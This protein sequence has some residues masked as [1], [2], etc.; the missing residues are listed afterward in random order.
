MKNSPWARS[1]TF[2]SVALLGISLPSLTKSAVLAKSDA[3][4]QS[5]SFLPGQSMNFPNR[6]FK[7]IEIRSTFPMRVLSGRCH[8]E[9]VVQFF[10]TSDQ[11]GDIFVTDL[12]KPPLLGTPEANQVTITEM[13]K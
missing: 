6:K 11:P 12:R 1:I 10:C 5:Y 2:T 4:V 7:R 8:E 9:Y 3:V 13:K